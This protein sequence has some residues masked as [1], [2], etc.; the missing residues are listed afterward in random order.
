MA[1]CTAARCSG[2][3][4]HA[5]EL[6]CGI[7]DVDA[8]HGQV[9]LGALLDVRPPVTKG[10]C[11]R[12]E[13]I[14]F[15]RPQGPVALGVLDEPG[16]DLER[17]GG[18]PRR[19]VQGVGAARGRHAEQRRGPVDV[20]QG[21]DAEGHQRGSPV[22]HHVEVAHPRRLHE[23]RTV[24]SGEA[25]DTQQAQRDHPVGVVVVDSR[26][27]HPAG[28]Q[29]GALQR[30][31]DDPGRDV[32]PQLLGGGR[33]RPVRQGAHRART[34]SAVHDDVGPTVEEPGRDVAQERVPDPGLSHRGRAGR[35]S[36]GPGR[37]RGG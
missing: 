15:R 18:G 26:R 8:H 5:A 13:R 7:R 2:V 12:V 4:P 1:E 22:A 25:L 24:L 30:A 19:A 29:V 10:A 33:A 3:P 27:L 28:Q 35:R 31:Q 9:V 17:L 23:H 34:R 20:T 11:R 6:A 37:G 14:G 21:A 16:E 32:V 36:A